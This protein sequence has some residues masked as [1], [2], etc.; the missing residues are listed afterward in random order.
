M[1][2]II[3]KTLLHSLWQGVLLA[4]LTALI[5][6]F[7]TR[8]NAKLRYNLFVGCLALFIAAVGTTFCI[9]L[10]NFVPS[11]SLHTMFL[12]NPVFGDTLILPGPTQNITGSV[13]L[14]NLVIYLNTYSS[15]IVMVWFL[16]ICAKSIRFMVDI[17]TLKQIKTSQVYHSGSMLAEK[18]QHLAAKYR[19]KQKVQILQS[20]IIKV[21]MVL[22]HFKPLILI[23]LGLINGLSMKE[24]DAILSHEMAHIKRRDYLVNILQSAA[25]ILFFFNPAVLWVSNMIKTEREHCCD[26]M[27]VNNVETKMDYI[28]ALV[29]CQEFASETPSYVMAING[30]K[31]N[32]IYRVQRLISSRN[33]PLNKLEKVIIGLILISAVGI[34]TAFSGKETKLAAVVKNEKTVF[35]DN[36]D[37]I[38]NQLLKDGLA[39]ADI[40][41]YCMLDKDAFM[42]NGKKQPAAIH[43]KYAQLYLKKGQKVSYRF[44]KDYK[45]SVSQQSASVRETVQTVQKAARAERAAA[46]VEASQ[47][48]AQATANTQEVHAVK[49]QSAAIDSQKLAAD[50]AKDQND[51]TKDL[52]ADRLIKDKTN[53]SYQ[54]NVDELII[55]GEKQ[56]DVIHRKYMRKYLKHAKQ[57]I[58]VSV[59]TN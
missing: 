53:L 48:K 9:E 57:N 13:F 2:S 8:A 28:K 19:I 56:S 21:P 41:I 46:K 36:S 22:G 14:D 39:K 50:K 44:E 17:R 49:A 5:V 37:S 47:A 29:L 45:N 54:L 18:V 6:L 42:I 3:F 43:A 32:L 7:T 35:Q 58:S 33:R 38:Y 40:E 30:G 59:S 55:D 15:S 1:E 31:S 20:G 16:I 11:A 24:V 12:G 10:N 25:E 52:I 34:S 26:D 51:M 27:A 4:L 23:P